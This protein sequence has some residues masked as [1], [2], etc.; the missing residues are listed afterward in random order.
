MGHI[1]LIIFCVVLSGAASAQPRIDIAPDSLLFG[2]VTPRQ[3]LLGSFEVY[4]RGTDTLV[5][6]DIE[7]SCG[8]ANA[9]RDASRVAFMETATVRVSL[10][11]EHKTGRFI[12]Y[13]KLKTNDPVTPERTVYCIADIVPVDSAK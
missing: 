5:I 1:R 7:T 11:I 2:R 9:V 13:V 8:C 6:K 10:N 3:F 12:Q 4:N